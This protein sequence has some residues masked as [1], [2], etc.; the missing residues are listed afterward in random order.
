MSK[1]LYL[2]YSTGC[3]ICGHDN[4]HGLSIQFYTLECI[5][6]VFVDIDIDTKYMSYLNTV[7][8]GILSALL[9]EAMGWAAFIYSDSDRF[10][11]TRSLEVTYKKPVQPNVKL[12]VSTEFVEMKRG[13]ATSKGMITD[14]DQKEVYT[15]SK[16][17][18]FQTSQ[19]KMEETKQY[20]IFNDD[21]EYHPKAIEY[22]RL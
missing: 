17:V 10:L 3:F 8:G 2:P 20:L 4:P 22:C 13:L 18:F 15:L 7:H 5:S 1:R 14:V 9:D 19:D 11:Y 16:G 12:L 21:K 6:K